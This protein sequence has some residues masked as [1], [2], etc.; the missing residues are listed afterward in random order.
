MRDQ[1]LATLLENLPI[2]SGHFQLESGYHAN[3]WLSLD[4]LFIDPGAFAPLVDALA[5]RLAQHDPTAICGP[6]VGGAFLAQALATKMG[7]EFLFTRPRTMKATDQLFAAE[8]ELPMPLQQRL[9]LKHARVAVVDDAISA[10]SSV[11]ATCTA[12][13]AVGAESV[14]IGT[15]ITLGHIG[16]TYFRSIGLPVERLAHRDFEM[17]ESAQCRLCRAGEPLERPV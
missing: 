11:R 17:W 12:L 3:L 5:D 13:R 14:V 10:G 4:A 1:D 15:L 16:A 2:R 8:Y 6:L 9:G 7:V